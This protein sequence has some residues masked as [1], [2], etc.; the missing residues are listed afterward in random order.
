MIYYLSPEQIL[1]LHR[2]QVGR[3][4]GHSGIRDRDALQAAAARPAMTFDG[5]DLYPDM[6]AKAAAL[7]HS[8]L[9]RHPFVDGSK[10]VAVHATLLFL[11]V[12]GWAWE[13]S[14]DALEGTTMAAA[15][16][17]MDVE[18]LTIWFRQ[19]IRELD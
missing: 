5:H 10:P 14:P 9:T 19:R 6:A 11:A 1:D 3:F 4:G 7:M 13:I 12:N 2:F 15:R 8:L 18:P 17:E 16:G